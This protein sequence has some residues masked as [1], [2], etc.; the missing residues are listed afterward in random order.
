MNKASLTFTVNDWATPQTV[1][2]TGE[3]DTVVDGDIDVTINVTVDQTAA[4]QDSGYKALNPSDPVVTNLD[5]EIQDDGT[6]AVP[7]ELDSSTSLPHEGQVTGA[8]DSYYHITGLTPSAV[9]LISTSSQTDNLILRISTTI[10]HDGDICLSDSTGNSGSESCVVTAPANGEVFIWSENKSNP[11]IGVLYTVDVIPFPSPEGAVNT[12]LDITSSL[13]GYLGVVDSTTSYYKVTGLA[14]STS[15]MV[16]LTDLRSDLELAVYDNAGF[17][18]GQLCTSVSGSRVAEACL[19]T[20]NSSGELYIQVN[21]ATGAIASSFKVDIVDPPVDEGSIASPVDLTGILP[22]DGQIK[23]K[24]GGGGDDTSGSFYVVG[25]LIPGAPV[26]VSAT[27]A[28]ESIELQV[29]S[30][31]DFVTE[32]LCDANG[33]TGVGS[34]ICTNVTVNP[35]GKLYVRVKSGNGFGTTG[36][37]HEINV[38]Q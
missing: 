35:S 22:W 4:T 7:L 33:T 25:G 11:A 16:R 9:Y 10:A 1:T 24:Q 36:G 32:I 6:L 26:S 21:P 13:P 31:A 20:S 2:V 14:A 37:T 18:T 23:S 38:I 19:A 15:F 5:N 27:N 29:G 34:E 12:P 28:S 17:S 3:N 8:G 30:N